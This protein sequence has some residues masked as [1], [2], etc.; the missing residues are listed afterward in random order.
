MI[1]KTIQRNVVESHDFKSE[2][3]TIDA[4]E[5]RYISSLLRNNYSD[6]ILATVRETFANAIDANKEANSKSPVS[7]F[8]PTRVDPNY[9]VRDF[10]RGLSE[11]QL[12][13]LY[14]KYGRS[15][16]RGDNL[17]IG[18]FG[19]GRFAP[20]SYTDSF[21]VTSHQ[22]GTAIV[23]SVYVDESG[24]TRFTKIAETKSTEPNGIQ[25]SV[26][27]KNGDIENFQTAITK[28]TFFCDEKF[29]AVNFNIFKPNWIVKNKDWGVHR[30]R[31]FG[32]DAMVV[33][34][35]VAY[36]LD[37]SSFENHPVASNK[38]F[39]AFSRS[40]FHQ[41]MVL[42]FPVGSLSLHHSREA[43]E[44]NVPT[45]NAIARTIVALEKEA[46][47]A[48]QKELDQISD[49]TEFFNKLR[50]VLNSNSIGVL[51]ENSTFIFNAP[52]GKKVSVNVGTVAPS[53]CFSLTSRSKNIKRIYERSNSGHKTLNPIQVSPISF[54]TNDGTA[55]LISDE[56]KNL[57][58]RAH[59]LLI[60]NS[61]LQRVFV[62]SEQQAK[63]SF[64]SDYSS[65]ASIFRASKVDFAPRGK[66]TNHDNFRL[67][68]SEHTYGTQFNTKCAAPT[69][70]F[71]YLPIVIK[72][73]KKFRSS[74]YVKFGGIEVGEPHAI[75]RLL[76]SMKELGSQISTV[77]G[78]L[79]TTDLPDFAINLHDVFVEKCQPVINTFKSFINASKEHQLYSS[80]FS[81][82]LFNGIEKLLPATHA[83]V[84]LVNK[85]K[86]CERSE[87]Y[88][89]RDNDPHYAKYLNFTNQ[90]PEFILKSEQLSED[91]VQ[92]VKQEVLTIKSRYPM[93]FLQIESRYM[94]SS[95]ARLV[96]AWAEYINLVD[97]S[98]S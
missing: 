13:G 10:G 67:I 80:E 92:K 65:H 31:N 2:I 15:T 66:G 94:Y 23:I 16:K 9:R 17:S 48:V 42:F 54:Y 18:G 36:P 70:A 62:V 27:V 51:C 6:T 32:G 53:A 35:G 76:R 25:I 29:D 96:K 11:A 33:M 12:F 50:E 91:F 44:Y 38:T 88:E 30:Q 57:D 20:L 49:V 39:Q 3:A 34:G 61:Q 52:D 72:G 43:L 59:N 28:V 87:G 24:D 5:M 8:C 98:Q 73:D 81:Y 47:S 26:A 85:C 14:T 55:I 83:L 40:Y 45:K 56:K 93:I 46:A 97:K 64:L 22:D 95:D 86:G 37:L 21:T 90:A 1:V 71:Y 74:W 82:R 77:Y 89:E 63:D 69:S 68:Y 58:R 79:D 60:K 4:E 19:I 75:V 84:N 7:I 41:N 78:V